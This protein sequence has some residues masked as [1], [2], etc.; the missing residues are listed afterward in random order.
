MSEQRP[1][2][3]ETQEDWAV[4]LQSRNDSAGMNGVNSL[5]DGQ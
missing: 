5:K 1:R 4:R 2:D 3:R